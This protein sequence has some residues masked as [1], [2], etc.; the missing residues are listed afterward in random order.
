MERYAMTQV[1][2]ALTD[3]VGARNA[4]IPVT[5][6]HQLRWM[7]R[8]ADDKGL[9]GAFVRIGRRK[10]IDPDLFHELARKQVGNT[11]T[12]ADAIRRAR[13]RDA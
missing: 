9:R 10:Y 2:I 8:T 7:E 11:R 12:V 13:H 3:V 5:T 4:G 6:T 1:L